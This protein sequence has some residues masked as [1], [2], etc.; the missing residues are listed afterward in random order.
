MEWKQDAETPGLI[1]RADSETEGGVSDELDF[2]TYTIDFW[3]RKSGVE[4]TP[5]RARAMISNVCGYFRLLDELD[6]KVRAKTEN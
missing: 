5:E 1:A 2:I 3:R 4:L 6:R